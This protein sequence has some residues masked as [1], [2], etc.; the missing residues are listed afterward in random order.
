MGVLL[1]KAVSRIVITRK[2]AV[3]I[4]QSKSG[5]II[6]PRPPK[7]RKFR[8]NFLHGSSVAASVVTMTGA[9][10]NVAA[11]RI[12]FIDAYDSFTHNIVSLLE[13]ELGVQVIIIK[14]DENIDDFITFLKSF[15][16]VIAGPGPGH[17]KNLKDVG[18]ISRLWELKDSD[19]LPVLGICLGFQSLVLAFGGS[20]EPLPEPRHG[21]V[22]NIRTSD[23]KIFA[24]VGDISAVQ[25]HSLCASIK[26]RPRQNNCFC[27]PDSASD[28]EAKSLCQDLHA[29]AWDLKEDNRSTDTV[30]QDENP[31]SILMAVA[32]RTKPYFGVQFHPESICS[33]ANARAVISVWWK[34][35]KKWNRTHRYQHHCP[36][37]TFNCL[38]VEPKGMCQSM[39]NKWAESPGF[40][41]PRSN[42]SNNLSTDGTSRK[43]LNGRQAL[44]I[45]ESVSNGISNHDIRDEPSK[46]QYDL[47]VLSQVLDSPDVTVPEICEELKLITGE[48]VLFDSECS[49]R[50]A[51]GIYSIIGITEPNSLKLEYSIGTHVV[52]LM[53]N[54][55][56][57]EVDFR[58]YG[59]TIFSYLKTFMKG[60]KTRDGNPDIPFWGGL[61]GYITYEAGLETLGI[62]SQP[63][64]LD[65]SFIFIRRSIVIDHAKRKL[66]V[67]SIKPND[68]DWV[69]RTAFILKSL[70][71]C[72]KAN[73][74]SREFTSDLSLPDEQIYKSKISRCQEF[75]RSGD[76]YELC[77]TTEARVWTP[78]DVSPWSLYLRLRKQNPA[79]F[80]TFM[81]L[82]P[83][84]HVSSSPER[85]LSWTR[86][87]KKGT[88]DSNSN[89]NVNGTITKTDD[90]HQLTS[91]CQFRPMKGTVRRQRTDPALP[92]V[93]LEEAT[94]ILATP[95][96]QAENLMIVDLIR[97]DLHGVVGSGNV[98]VTK[99]MVVEEYATLY[100]LV[101]VIEGTLR[102]DEEEEEEVVLG[103]GI[104]DG[105]FKGSSHDCI[106]NGTSNG[107]SNGMSS[108]SSNGMSNG[109]SNDSFND[110]TN[111]TTRAISNS[112]LNTTTT[113]PHITT[114]PSP[115]P[116]NPTHPHHQ[117]NPTSTNQTPQ[118][119]TYPLPRRRKDNITGIDVLAASLP[120]G[121]MTGAPKK[122]SCSILQDLEQRNRGVYSGVV[123]YLDVGG[124]G[125]FSV[126]IRSA[127]RWDDNGSLGGGS[128]GD[129]AEG[130]SLTQ[131][132]HENGNG[133]GILQDT[134]GA[135][136]INYDH[137]HSHHY[138]TKTKTNT[139]KEN[140][141]DDDE[142][143]KPPPPPQSPPPWLIG[144]GGAITCL[145]TETGEWEEMC[146][147][148]WSTVGVFAGD[149]G[150]GFKG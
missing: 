44:V 6:Q 43:I 76:S 29:L 1:F 107:T 142:K 120:P 52:R 69:S 146:G 118:P 128:L 65:L 90:D 36:L 144:A 38:L 72:K 56:V 91:I 113:P 60:Y 85:F 22:R 94:R 109:S 132:P 125:D 141:N 2:S 121:S 108:G 55:K 110:T 80:S 28:Q 96:E 134:D 127:S 30:L 57:D 61:M 14:I 133:D 84:T 149:K 48:V 54:G 20:V 87:S 117:Q 68:R 41:N 9:G 10:D 49:Q 8:I 70:H 46:H 18:L 58:A 106:C 93:T 137:D 50:P 88:S 123:G 59:D 130:G 23:E 37:V 83:L 101:T 24:G 27:V 126:V 7:C 89:R 53:Q 25:Y 13:M 34:I 97:H 45:P 31:G 71:P 103:N 66:Y 4:E 104:S 16:A 129:G 136:D 99:L 139:S 78:P 124:A 95:K 67:Q 26:E 116:P 42:S 21:M 64:P 15:A 17:P 135:G 40:T 119:T 12:L 63:N 98:E 75:L 111:K 143:R 39:N 92:P 51:T 5:G 19:V 33:D 81:R 150:G 138:K 145:S 140:G 32:H 112:T 115:S 47:M 105:T 3:L 77:L 86:P 147:K 131:H 74:L 148:L 102:T 73:S 11:P 79:P 35:A 122:R 82:G 100:Q 114:P 62:R